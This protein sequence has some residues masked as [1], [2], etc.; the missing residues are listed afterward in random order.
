MFIINLLQNHGVRLGSESADLQPGISRACTRLLNNRARQGRTGASARL[1]EGSRSSAGAG[2]AERSR[3]PHRGC[4]ASD[5]GW[6]TVLSEAKNK[7]N[8]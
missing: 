4:R 3:M 7:E 5:W 8:K 1:P 2:E 6:T